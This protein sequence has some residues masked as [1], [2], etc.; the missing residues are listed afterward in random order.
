MINPLKVESKIDQTPWIAP[1]SDC[2]PK[3][4]RKTSGGP[5]TPLFPLVS[6]SRVHHHQYRLDHIF[7]G[8]FALRDRLKVAFRLSYPKYIGQY[9]LVNEGSCHRTWA[10]KIFFTLILQEAFLRSTGHRLFL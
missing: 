10:L 2:L 3:H 6:N 7:E 9:Q 8:I 5:S 4:R 1:E